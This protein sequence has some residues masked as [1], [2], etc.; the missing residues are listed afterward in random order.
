M[1]AVIPCLGVVDTVNQYKPAKM[2]YT[3]TN[4]KM[5]YILGLPII[6][7]ESV[8]GWTKLK[9]L[10]LFANSFYAIFLVA[11]ITINQ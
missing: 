6:A 2:L 8:S 4:L 1:P 11:R 5:E 9:N 7:Q 10:R 3:E